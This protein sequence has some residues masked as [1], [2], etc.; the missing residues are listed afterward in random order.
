MDAWQNLKNITWC[1]KFDETN[2]EKTG[3]N[4]FSD[5]ETAFLGKTFWRLL[6][7]YKNGLI[8]YWLYNKCQKTSWT[9]I[10]S[11]LRFVTL[12]KTR[13][14][15]LIFFS[16]ECLPFCLFFQNFSFSTNNQ[17]WPFYLHQICLNTL[18]S[19]IKLSRT[20]AKLGITRKIVKV[21]FFTGKVTF[22]RKF[23]FSTRT[24]VI[25]KGS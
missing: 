25:P 15:K 14:K 7:P 18:W 6:Y 8:S 1:R 22:F 21:F 3:Q 4:F 10:K 2:S 20:S 12:G 17:N 13:R 9:R 24:Y 11:F 5:E 19:V 23:L 16:L